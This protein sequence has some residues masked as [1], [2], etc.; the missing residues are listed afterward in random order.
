MFDGNG[1]SA[2]SMH[3]IEVIEQFVDGEHV[4]DVPP[5]DRTEEEHKQ[6]QAELDEESARVVAYEPCPACGQPGR[7]LHEE[8]EAGM[9]CYVCEGWMSYVEEAQAY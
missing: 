8:V 3:E 1:P 5:D 9:K 2:E 4:F 7:M 6:R